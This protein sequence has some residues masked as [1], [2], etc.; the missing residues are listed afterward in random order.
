MKTT[1]YTS[2]LASLFFLIP[3]LLAAQTNVHKNFGGI[4]KIRMTTSS[5]SCKIQKA[6]GTEVEIDLLHTFDQSSYEPRMEQEGDRLM[7]KENFRKNNNNGKS[8][9]TL[10]IPEGLSVTFTTGSGNLEVAGLTIELDATTGSGDLLFTDLKGDVEGTTGSGDVELINF[11]GEINANTG[12]GN[13]RVEKSTGD[14]SLNC[15][16]GNLKLNDNKASFS[17]NTGSGNITAR[18]LTLQ[19]SSRFNTGSGDAEVVLAATP[20]FDLTV[21][22]GSGDAELNFNGNEIKGEIVMKASKKHGNIVAPFNFDKTEEID[23]YGDNTTVVKTAVKGNGTNR[24]SVG[25]GSGSA[26][27][28]K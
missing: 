19:G 14:I 13:M 9:W 16:S 17:A 3:A 10:S 2:I 27:I 4:K 6:K 7:I 22:S 26:I 8:N 24:I 5:G 23:N 25:T 20:A 12:S 21:N 15:G 18:N 1:R 28:K 11:N